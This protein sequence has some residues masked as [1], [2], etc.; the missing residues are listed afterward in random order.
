[1]RELQEMVCCGLAYVLCVL[2]HSCCSQH[3][4]NK[5]EGVLL[6]REMT[7]AVML[8]MNTK[9]TYIIRKSQDHNQHQINKQV[10]PMMSCRISDNCDTSHHHL[11]VVLAENPH[12]QYHVITALL[13]RPWSTI[14]WFS[15]INFYCCWTVF[16][17]HM[18]TMQSRSL[19]INTTYNVFVQIYMYILNKS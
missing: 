9:V 15:V 6:M 12:R 11:V 8:M 10:C 16:F 14:R 13:T 19:Y 5:Q 2:E 18:Y 7:D 3:C 17:T 4:N 1:M